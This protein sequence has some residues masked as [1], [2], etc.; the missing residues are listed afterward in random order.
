[1]NKKILLIYNPVAGRDSERPTAL[2]IVS[3]FPADYR[4]TV[5][6][7]YGRGS[8]TELVRD[9]GAECEMIVICGGDGTLHEAINGLMSAEM[10]KPIGYIPIG[11][12]NDLAVALGIPQ[13][14][15]DAVKLIVSG[16][17]KKI[18]LGKIN[19]DYFTYVACFGPGTAIS[20]STPQSLKNKIGYS[21]Y[22]FNGFVLNLFHTV[23]QAKPKRLNIECDGKVYDDNYYF[24][25]IS[26]ST[27]VAGMFRY[28]ENDISLN[29]GRFE[30][31][32]VRKVKNP[33]DFF[34][35]FHKIV[36]REYDDDGL[37][38]FKASHIKIVFEKKE[39]WSLD[40]ES[41]SGVESADISVLNNAVE[42]FSESK[43]CD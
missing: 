26:N 7:T 40:G 37:L 5:R 39:D 29:D 42:I 41:M 19:G 31:I 8:G 14:P 1:M 24:G 18:D 22:M 35:V 20:Y 36:K 9:Y 23:K 3:L 27:S 21:A 16:G 38:Y 32:L 30:V 12:T 11:S 13:K 4:I 28:D 17:I 15:E 6:Y 43:L 34:R 2:D 10:K 33:L 25:A